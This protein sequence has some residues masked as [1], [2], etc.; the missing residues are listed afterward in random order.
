[1]EW[2]GLGSSGTEQGKVANCFERGNEHS[3]SI[4]RCEFRDQ[5]MKCELLIKDCA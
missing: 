5:V 3:G 1:M 2:Y 4:K